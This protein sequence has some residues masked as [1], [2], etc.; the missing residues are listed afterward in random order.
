V[1]PRFTRTAA[2]SDLF[3]SRFAAG[4]DIAFLGGVLR[5]GHREQSHR[6]RYLANYTNGRLH[7]ERGFKLPEDGLYSGF[8]ANPSQTYDRSSWTYEEGNDIGGA[9]PAR[10]ASPA[11][12]KSTLQEQHWLSPPLPALPAKVAYDLTCSIPDACSN[13]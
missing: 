13:C 12:V 9:A 8:D 4:A 7:R 2:T 11:P 1:D 10:T 5:Y 6:E 3:S